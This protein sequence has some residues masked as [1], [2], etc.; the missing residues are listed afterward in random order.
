MTDIFQVASIGMQDANLRMDSISQNA[1]GASMPGY[2]RHV[3]AGGGFVSAL[4]ADAAL[5]GAANGGHSAAAHSIP[6]VDLHPGSL[7]ATSR[8]LD[9]AIE[10][11]DLFF[12]LTDGNR[13]WLTRSGSFRL[14]TDGILVGEKGLR[15][16]GSNGDI[17]LPGINVTVEA[18]G[19][20][21]QQGAPVGAIQLFRPAERAS[22]AAAEGAL[23]TAAAGIDPVAAGEGRLRAGA[24]ESSNTNAS[25]EMVGLM[26]VARQ[27]EALGRIVQGY[28]GVLQR[29]I[30][31]LAEV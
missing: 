4:V 23:L 7:M 6:Q 30:E 17:H 11:D 12:A 16:V 5:G 3:I 15:V 2:R 14:D 10:S 18:D 28:D 21:L 24:L 29:A 13:T 31:K 26:T 8:S 19:Q 22:L 20:I 1:A 9:V 27:F 25:D